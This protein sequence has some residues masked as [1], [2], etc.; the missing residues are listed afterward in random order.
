MRPPGLPHHELN[1][2]SEETRDG[3]ELHV[4]VTDDV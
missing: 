4:D 3:K 1:N 2:Q